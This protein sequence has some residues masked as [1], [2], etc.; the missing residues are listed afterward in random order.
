[1]THAV[2]ASPL[3]VDRLRD[4]MRVVGVSTIPSRVQKPLPASPATSGQ[5]RTPT[6]RRGTRAPALLVPRAPVWLFHF[7][8]FYRGSVGQVGLFLQRRILR[9]GSVRG[10]HEY[11]HGERNPWRRPPARGGH[12]LRARPTYHPLPSFP[13]GCGIVRSLDLEQGGG[14]IRVHPYSVKASWSEAAAPEETRRPWPTER[15]CPWAGPASGL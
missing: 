2:P 6:P 9:K 13:T 14:D 10:R 8:G 12:H 5:R 7:K 11:P 4:R 1:M 3:Q 15:A